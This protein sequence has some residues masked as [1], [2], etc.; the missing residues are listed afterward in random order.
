LGTP[1]N[2][3]LSA[4]RAPNKTAAH[5]N[6]P[7]YRGVDIETFVRDSLVQIGRGVQAANGELN[8]VMQSPEKRV[9]FAIERAVRSRAGGLGYRGDGVEG[10]RRRAGS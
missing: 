10:G 9:Y 7:N 3:R 8:T 4:D 5:N 1:V 2:Q 6:L